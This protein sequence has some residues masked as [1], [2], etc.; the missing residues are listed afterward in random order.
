[1]LKQNKWLL[2]IYFVHHKSRY[3]HPKQVEHGGSRHS[4]CI[5]APQELGAYT[6]PPTPVCFSSV[7]SEWKCRQES[8]LG[9]FVMLT[10]ALLI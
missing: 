6:L 9:L 2:M 3:L 10:D 5:T 7:K 1:M 8:G 4:L